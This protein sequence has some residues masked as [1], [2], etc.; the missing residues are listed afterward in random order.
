MDE[1]RLTLAAVV[2]LAAYGFGRFVVGPMSRTSDLM[3]SLFVPPDRS[4][5][6]PHGVQERDEP[7]GWRRPEAPAVEVLGPVASAAFEEDPPRPVLDLDPGRRAWS[8]PY[9]VAVGRV[10]PIQFVVRGH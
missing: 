3:A 8:G 7:W 5:G 2:I 1:T 10:A 6:W 4:L 9:V